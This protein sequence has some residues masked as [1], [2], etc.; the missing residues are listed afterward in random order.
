MHACVIIHNMIIK[1][2]HKTQA[3]HVGSYE[4]ESPLVDVD[5]QVLT[6]FADFIAIQILIQIFMSNCKKNLIRE[7]S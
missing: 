3:R 7:Y 2:D 1:N 6:D 4:C 5:H